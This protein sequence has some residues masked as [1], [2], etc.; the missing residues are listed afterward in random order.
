MTIPGPLPNRYT[1]LI[2]DLG[3]VLMYNTCAKVLYFPRPSF[4][5]SRMRLC[6]EGAGNHTGGCL[7]CDIVYNYTFEC[8]PL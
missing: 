4:S 5:I 2:K 8:E 6:I 3:P 1:K 7:E